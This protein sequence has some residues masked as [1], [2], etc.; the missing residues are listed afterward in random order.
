M[1]R[2]ICILGSMLLLLPV[3]CTQQ[4]AMGCSEPVPVDPNDLSVTK[5]ECTGIG[6][7]VS[8]LIRIHRARL[9]SEFWILEEP[10]ATNTTPIGVGLD[11]RYLNDLDI[12]SRSRALAWMNGFTFNCWGPPK[13]CYGLPF[14]EY[15]V[16]TVYEST[17]RLSRNSTDEDEHGAQHLLSFGVRSLEKIPMELSGAGFE[18]EDDDRYYNAVGS[19]WPLLVDGADAGGDAA[20]N[21]PVIGYS[22][23]EIIMLHAPSSSPS[24]LRAFLKELGVTDAVRMDAGDSA[25]MCMRNGEGEASCVGGTSRRIPYSIGL[26]TLGDELVRNGGFETPELPLSPS[27]TPPGFHSFSGNPILQYVQW[28]GA[29]FLYNAPTYNERARHIDIPP[30]A[31][32]GQQVA[33]LRPRDLDT[34][35]IS[36]TLTVPANRYCMLHFYHGFH[37]AT[38]GC[39]FQA[40]ELTLSIDG[41]SKGVER[42]VYSSS[43]TMGLDEE[44]LRFTTGSSSNV[45]L[46]FEASDS[47]SDPEREG[48]CEV[49][50]D[51]VSV[52]CAQ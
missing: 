17:H 42:L 46:K 39:S 24:R 16:T 32:H 8:T 2:W 6:D 11:G 34:N 41:T 38:E 10:T 35:Y 27:R 28:D 40:S 5:Q 52:S 4:M 14:Q 30:V 9:N 25:G 37:P 21:W 26:V 31:R 13:L 22:A 50:L 18:P 29:M 51:D 20:D 19:T 23:G 47:E 1:N 48:P 44:W 33:A 36:Q 12:Q 3:G 45:T 7:G 15:P 43:N 49:L